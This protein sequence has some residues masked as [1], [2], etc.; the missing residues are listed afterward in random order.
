MK[1]DIKP[2]IDSKAYQVFL[3]TSPCN[4]PGFFAAHTWF[5]VNDHGKLERWEHRFKINTQEK[6]WSHIHKNFLPPFQ[7][8]GYF[9]GHNDKH[10]K[11]KLLKV[12]EGPKA[13]SLANFIKNSPNSYPLMGKARWYGP[14]SNTYT[15]WILDNFPELD[16]KLPWN[17]IGKGYKY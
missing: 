9:Y 17:A 16:I 1:K 14:N 12:I 2:R 4:L 7:G 3:L 5:V 10:W 13:E 6:S 15:R 11:A 8:L